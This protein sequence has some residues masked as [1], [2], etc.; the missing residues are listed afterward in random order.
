MSHLMENAYDIKEL[1]VVKL[2]EN[3]RDYLPKIINQGEEKDIEYFNTNLYYIVEKF[4]IDDKKNGFH[5]F[6]TECII[7]RCFF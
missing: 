5:E 3:Y 1:Y 7:G 2:K 4:Q 6:Y